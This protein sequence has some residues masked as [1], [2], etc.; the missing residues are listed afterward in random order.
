MENEKI[1]KISSL[2]KG[3]FGT[4]VVTKTVPQMRKT[5]NPYVNRVE[6]I[7]TY[8]NAILGVSYENTVNNRLERLGESAV[9]E[10][11]APKGKLYYNDFFYQSSKDENVFYLKLGIY[12]KTTE[13]SSEYYIDGRPATEQEIV[14]LK[15]FMP[16]SDGEIK[17]QSEAGLPIEEQYKMITPKLEN[18]VKIIAG[19]KEI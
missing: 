15:S 19:K 2:T 16:N 10:A 12:P 5:G 18:V 17:K 14:E 3:V 7:S 4:T 9:Y 11:S 13:I 1:S 8:K 6:K